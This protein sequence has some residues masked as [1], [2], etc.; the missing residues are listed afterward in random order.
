MDGAG[1]DQ[2]TT[3]APLPFRTKAVYALGDHTINLCLASLLFLFP[4]FLTETAGMRPALA[5]LVPLVGR[6]VDA[7]SD[8]AMGRLSDATLWRAGRRRPYFLIGMLPLG[9]AFAA[10]WWAVPDDGGSG[11]FI[12][13]AGAYVLF[14]VAS[15]VVAVP[16]LS[17]I[18]EMT[19]SYDE[20]TS[21][22]AFRAVGAIL[23]ALLAAAVLPFVVKAFGG[24]AAAW[25]RMGLLAGVYV[26][27]PW[28]FVHRVTFERPAAQRPPQEPFFRSLISRF[29]HRSY[30]VLVGLFLLGRIA[31]DMTSS[32]F[33]LFFMYRLER[34]E[35]FSWTM[36]VFLSTVALSMPVWN[37]V[38]RR[39]DKR[40][41]F[42]MG[43]CWWVGSQVFLFLATPEWS[44]WIVFV[45]AAIGGVGYA[46][47]DMI[48]WSMLGEVVDEDELESG[49]RR[50]GLYFGLFTFLRKAGGA[51]GVAGAFAVLDL[52]GYRGGQAVEDAPV[53]WI[54]AFT[55]V[56]PAVFV[57]LAAIVAL[58]FPLGRARHA[59]ILGELELRRA[60]RRSGS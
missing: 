42:L 45:G 25:Q 6:L 18:P 8:P 41:I 23:G 33:P 35:D 52:A 49:E 34:P 24:D 50:E 37:A 36:L 9:G 60:A 51:L 47:A 31:I 22:N 16:Y 1:A 57:V 32:M 38:A 11:Q 19:S 59:E 55:A 29:Q 2:A 56:F 44:R 53:E 39:V 43:A 30:V 27:L 26:V 21:L 28:I 14:S 54:R 15:T 13:Y 40:T 3:D 4:S 10:L 5:G 48:P 20:R 12:Y 46:A 7:F 17:L 58:R